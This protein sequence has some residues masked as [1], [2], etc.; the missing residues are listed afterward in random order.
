MVQANYVRAGRLVRVLRGPRQDHIGVIVD[1]IDANRLLVEN[2]QDSKMR[3]HVV[4]MSNITPLKF[5]VKVPRNCSTKALKEALVSTKALEKY[6][7]TRTATRISA[8]KALATSTDFE[9]YQ[10][11][12]ARRSRAH[13]TRKVFDENDAKH[14]VSWHKV[15]LKKVQKKAAKVDTTA[16]AKKRI[17]KAI[18]A[19]KSKK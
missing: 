17:S 6:A 4:K 11:R 7:A 10:L 8:K 19:R 2:P 12:V 1:I 9:R 18:A 14:P 16:A 15:A 5:A 3:R 13:W